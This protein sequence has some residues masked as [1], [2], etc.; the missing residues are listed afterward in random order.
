MNKYLI[1]LGIA[2]GLMAFM[3]VY[4]AEI[5]RKIGLVDK[6]GVRKLHAREVPL[7]GG[8]GIGTIFFLSMLLMPFSLRD[9]RLMFFSGSVLLII[10]ILDDRR[11]IPAS[12]KLLGQIGVCTILVVLDGLR[13]PEIGDIFSLGIDQGLSFLAFPFTVLGL[14]AIINAINMI[15]GHDGLAGG[16]CL[17]SLVAL[18]YLCYRG[19]LW[20]SFGI[21]ILLSGLVGVFLLFNIGLF[22]AARQVF[23]GDA[24]S[25]F[26]G[27]LLGIF[28]IRLNDLSLPDNI[29]GLGDVV[30]KTTAAPWIIGLPLADMISSMCR[31]LFGYKPV[32]QA[33]R[34]HVHH[35]LDSLGYHRFTTLSVLLSAH[36]IFVA[37]GV[38][39]T[40]WDWPDVYL[41]WT[42]LVLIGIYVGQDVYT[43][44][45]LFAKSWKEL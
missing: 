37:I 25:M 38:L 20:D 34:G 16:T 39:G 33:D 3:M 7:I 6:P 18:A 24:G 10:G 31:R 29:S 9:Y 19:G 27:L 5:A 1:I 44:R 42:P 26:L 21:M 11:D 30:L 13:V 22:G 8:I 4:L 40:V 43:Q 14:V 17:I 2:I 15:D 35:K 41:F 36:F 28:L 45:K 23:L 12:A 32:M